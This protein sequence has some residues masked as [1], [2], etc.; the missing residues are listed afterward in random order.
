MALFF[1]FVAEYYF[2]VYVCVCVC[3]CVYH[4]F[5]IHSSID[6]HLNYFHILANLNNVVMNLEGA[7]AFVN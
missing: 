4:T 2:C 6:G 5:F 1:F 3:V 7:Y